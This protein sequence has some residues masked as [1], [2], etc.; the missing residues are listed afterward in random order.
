MKYWLFFILILFSCSKKNN[1]KNILAQVNNTYLY[2]DDLPQELKNNFDNKSNKDLVKMFI[3]KWVENQLLIQEANDKLNSNDKNFEKQLEDYQNSLLIHQLKEKIISEK[4]DTS[5]TNEE[6][7]TFY[8]ENN[9]LFLLN[10]NIVKIRYVKINK[11]AKEISKIK[12]LMQNPN[13]QNDSMLKLICQGKA[14]N[15]YVDNQWLYL[16]EITKEIPLDPNYDQQRFLNSNKFLSFQ[17][18]DMLYLV[19]LIDFKLKNNS[20]PFELE[21]ENIKNVF[22][23]QRKTKL[24]ED[25]QKKLLEKS[26]EDGKINYHLK[27]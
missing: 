10:Q 22:L 3:D 11:N 7:L 1:Q 24:I 12:Q 27:N 9:Q 23:Y 15:F 2:Q 21:K 19:Y 20:S 4:L 26:I 8:N 5:V 14:E 25:F 18:F 16:D 13:R 17:E 6:L